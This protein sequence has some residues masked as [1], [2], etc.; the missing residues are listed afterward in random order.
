MISRIL[1][2]L[3]MGGIIYLI[4]KKINNEKNNLKK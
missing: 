3:I 1:S 2:W 4:Y